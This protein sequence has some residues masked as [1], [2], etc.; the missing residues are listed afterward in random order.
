MAKVEMCM[1][2]WITLVQIISFSVL[3][4]AHTNLVPKQ[5]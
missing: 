1:Q 4:L 3:L 5:L 2:N